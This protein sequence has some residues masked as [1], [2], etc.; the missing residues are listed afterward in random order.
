MSS[1]EPVESGRV[2]A[3]RALAALAAVLVVLIL[4][5]AGQARAAAVDD[6][7]GLGTWVDLYDP[8]QFADPEGTV[9][10]MAARG[11]RTLYLE[12]GNYKQ[13]SD[14]Y[15]PGRLARFVDAAHASGI[16]VVAWYL[17]SFKNI[18]RDLR[19]SLAAIE[20][21]TPAGG[22]FDS[23]A[24]DIEAAVVKSPA[25]RSQRLLQ[26]SRRLRAAVGESYPLGAIIPSPRG[27]QLVSS[28]WP[29]FPYAELDAIYDVFLPMTYFS[30]RVEGG[31]AVE[32]YVVRS[33]AIIRE[34]TGN[35]SVPIHVIGGIGDKTSRLEARGFMRAALGCRA[36][37]WSVYDYSVTRNPTWKV[38]TSP[39]AAA[40]NPSCSG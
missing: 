40:P 3:A 36:L 1:R 10:G 5:A 39:P 4:P 32:D 34:K 12:T 9:A 13:R 33:M 37:G 28:Y 38:L 21:R 7:R 11:V 30:Y 27:M 35:P 23:F 14:L 20:F 16:R 29:G 19:R 17:P 25:L 26:L 6:Y 22:R 31:R 24:L 15:R 2:L 8:A 18:A